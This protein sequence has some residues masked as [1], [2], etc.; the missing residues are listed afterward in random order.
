[1]LTK[2]II[3]VLKFFSLYAIELCHGVNNSFLQNDYFISLSM[4]SSLS[5]SEFALFLLDSHDCQN[6]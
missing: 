4:V 2:F 1:M 3:I 5:T 6:M